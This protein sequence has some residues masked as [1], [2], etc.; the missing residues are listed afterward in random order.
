MAKCYVRVPLGLRLS[1][2]NLCPFTGIP[3][4]PARVTV[5]YPRVGFRIPIPLLGTVWAKP[6]T[7]IRFP[8]SRLKG[9][10]DNCLGVLGIL[11]W[12]VF[13]I[14]GIIGETAAKE[15]EEFWRIT[16]RELNRDSINWTRI[17]LI[18]LCL[19]ILLKVLRVANL[20]AVRILGRDAFSA[21]LCFRREDYARQFC[22]LDEL[23]YHDHPCRER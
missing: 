11:I 2:P 8:C 23:S 15:G 1:F 19:A 21:E 3:N 7:R 9:S 6:T 14:S 16:G 20:R 13:L 4:P 5:R 12:V 22:A 18:T 10:I 17:V